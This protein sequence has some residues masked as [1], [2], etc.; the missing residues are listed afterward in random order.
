MRFGEKRKSTCLE[1]GNV[2]KFVDWVGLICLVIAL[3]I[4][5]QFRQIVLLIFTAVVITVSLNSLVRRLMHRTGLQRGTAVL[6]TLLL[7]LMAFAIF[8][9]LVL[10]LFID[11]FQQLL[12]LIPAGM[13]RLLNLINEV[14]EN[15]PSWIP[16]N[17]NLQLLPNFPALLQQLGSIGSMAFGNFFT[18][19]SNSV[20]ILLQILLMLVL[21][22]MLL[23]APL[24]YRAMFVRLFPSRYRRRTDEILDQCEMALLCWLGGVSLSSLFVASVSF[25]G[26]SLM[27]VQFAFAHAVIAGVFNFIPNLGPTLSAVFP[28]SVAL[29]DS[30]SKVVAVIILY[31]VIQNIESYWFSP[32]IMQR[33][34]S[35]LPAATLIAQI[36]FATFFGPL[37]LILALPLAVVSK[38]WIEE[39]WIK[40]VLDERPVNPALKL[41]PSLAAQ[42][43]AA[44]SPDM[45]R[46]EG[47]PPDA[48]V[49][50]SSVAE[51]S[52]IPPPTVVESQADSTQ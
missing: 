46:R 37:G 27:G 48:L 14:V 7:V 36:F 34:V 11:Q 13:Q 1:R 22:I 9:S 31:V 5:W 19:F 50:D 43:Q 29:L 40:D 26:L 16:S 3:L 25:L 12:K 6:V 44:Q 38:V 42:E 39:A 18:F 32:M 17:P 47:Q 15:P 41:S 35:L 49:A 51:S 30:P 8:A 21:S 20:A 33:Q 52:D 2:V 10:P 24:S 45:L 23:A 28:V 4:L